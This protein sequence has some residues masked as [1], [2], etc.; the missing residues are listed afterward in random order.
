MEIKSIARETPDP[1][2]AEKNLDRFFSKLKAPE[3]FIGFLNEIAL[4]FSYSQ[5]LSNY[6]IQFPDRL[7]YALQTCKEPITRELIWREISESLPPYEQISEDGLM[8]WVRFF[9]RDIL[10]RITLRDILCLAETGKVLEELTFLAEGIIETALKAS[11]MIMRR[12]FGDP[13]SGEGGLVLI[14]VGKL[15]G[16]D[17][18]YSSDVDLIGVYNSPDGETSGQL[19][20][21]GVRVNRISTHEYYNKV[22]ETLSRVLSKQTPDGIG[23]R[24]DL[25]LRPQG[26]RGPLAQPLD[27]CRRYYE[28]W[29]RTWERMVM[30]RAR[31]VAGDRAV[32]DGFMEIIQP[33]VWKS[34]D[35]T[36]IDEIRGMKKKID[37][38]F[39]K[40]D[41]KRGY[42]GIREIEFFVQTFQLLYGSEIRALRTNRLGEAIKGLSLLKG[43]DK[44]EIV[45]LWETYLY[46]RKVEN[47]LQM[48]DDLQ[49]HKLPD[50]ADELEV[51]GRKMG[52]G[53]SQDF[54]Q[55]LRVKRMGVKDMYNSLL[56][57]E[58]DV[59]AEALGIL[60]TELKDEEIRSYLVIK[61][62][63]DPESGLKSLRSLRDQLN[64]YRSQKERRLLRKV[65]PVFLD[66]AMRAPL[67]ERALRVLEQFLSSFGRDE[68]YLEWFS[69]QER[70]IRGIVKLFSM[71]VYLGR[72]FLS[73]PIF[74]DLL[75]E[76]MSIKKRKSEIE[77]QLMRYIKT[78]NEDY[79]EAV[80]EY[81][82]WEELR[83][84]LLFFAGYYDIRDLMRMLSLLAETVVQIL[85]EKNAPSSGLLAIGM[86]KLGGREITYGSDLDIIY[87]ADVPDAFGLAEVITR[88][89]SRYTPKGQL[90][91]IDLRLRPDGS[92]GTIVKSMEGLRNYYLKSAQPWEV[93]ALL[94]AVPIAGD[95][96]SRR[97]FLDL[98]TEVLERRGGELRWHLIEEMRQR[99]ISQ[100]S[101]REGV[102]DL[103]FGS[104]GL[105]DIEFFTQWLQISSIKTGRRILVS[106]TLEALRR[107]SKAGV[108]TRPQAMKLSESYIFLRTVETYLRLDEMKGL[109]RGTQTARGIARLL[110]MQDE[111]ELINKIAELRE[112]VIRLIDEMGKD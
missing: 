44:E 24:C 105:E 6:S 25:R 74:L 60:E 5:F 18:N 48:R 31:P 23:Y 76:G 28:N 22:L 72:V 20:P 50:G 95:M 91:Q 65:L 39:S 41:I 3:P 45:F 37:S 21:S 69:D 57:T 54:L 88:E 61:G 109:K 99:I 103:K 8:Q 89:L 75:M 108:I 30:I 19:T 82:K 87:V 101:E 56:G 80:V 111:T 104:G 27:S 93:Q 106:G 40:E 52:Y 43:L 11:D 84:G 78:A 9:K 59:R 107:L 112:D 32:G 7:L 102:I 16:E 94:K 34:P 77:K 53:G 2:R 64:H 71:S 12:R 66:E 29:A 35:Y 85:I 58:D 36:E 26:Q 51:L 98:R 68:A 1:V 10:L 14:G 90:Y 15:G 100:V 73:N 62:F 63:T 17:L 96:R 81:K 67:P 110:G 33:F 38:T 55:D 97:A 92:K 13:P 70:F 79:L 49:V 46:L 47:Y 42:G 86:G 83:T 4:L